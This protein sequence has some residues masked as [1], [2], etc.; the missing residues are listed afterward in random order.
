MAGTN[1]TFGCGSFLPGYGPFNFPDFDVNGGNTKG[2][3]GG[4]NSQPPGGPIVTEPPEGSVCECRMLGTYTV[5]PTGQTSF[6][7]IF[8]RLEAQQRCREIVNGIPVDDSATILQNIRL[9]ITQQGGSIV[10]EQGT[11][12]GPCAGGAP[13]PQAPC[14]GG[15]CPPIVIIY[16]IPTEQGEG[17]DPYDVGE[18]PPPP[19]LAEPPGP[20][21]PPPPSPGVPGGGGILGGVGGGGGGGGGGGPNS[22]VP[23]APNAPG[24]TGVGDGGGVIGEPVDDLPEA[25]NPSAPDPGGPGGGGGSGPNSGLPTS[26]E[27]PGPT[28]VEGGVGGEGGTPIEGGAEIGLPAPPENRTRRDYLAPETRP[29]EQAVNNLFSTKKINLSDPLV[30]RTLLATSP[31]GLQDPEVFISQ[32]NNTSKFV[33]NTSDKGKDLFADQIDSTLLYLLNTSINSLDWDSSKATSFSTDSI[34][35]SLKPEVR[36]IVLGIK[37]YNGSPISNDQIFSLIG[38]RVLDGTIDQITFSLLRDL[39]NTTNEREN[40]EISRSNNPVVNEIA[41]L[42]LMESTFFPLNFSGAGGLARNTLKNYKSLASDV[43]RYVD[44]E[45]GGVTQRHYV[46]DDDTFVTR[47]TLSL[48]D[49]EFFEV[50]LAGETTRFYAKSEDDHAFIV[51]Q[52]IR[53]TVINL[54]GGTPD[55][56]ISVSGLAIDQIEETYSL[57]GA[58]KNLYFLSCVLDTVKS[59]PEIGR[60]RLLN[61]TEAEFKYV[62]IENEED[63]ASINEFI[64]NKANFE[65]YVLNEE[66]LIF[67]YIEGGSNLK[68]SQDDVIYEAPKENKTNPILLRQV[69]RYLILYPTNRADFLIFNDKSTI[70]EYETSATNFDEEVTSS[71]LVTRQLRIGT[72]ICPKFNIPFSTLFVKTTSAGR[73]GQDVFGSED[74]QA[75]VQVLDVDSKIYSEGFKPDPKKVDV[76]ATNDAVRARQ[77]TPLRLSTEILQEIDNNYLLGKNGIG[78]S[79]TEFDLFSRFNIV[80]YNK[81]IRSSDYEEIKKSLFAGSVRGVK[82]VPAVRAAD[83][84]IGLSKTQLITRRADAPADT[85]LPIKATA[86]GRILS[87]PTD[88]ELPQETPAPAVSPRPVT[89]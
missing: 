1:P 23:N 28:G 72:S 47:S 78:K 31:T 24:P 67:D 18:D 8:Y 19:P 30:E 56:L 65:T 66:D 33:R 68:L 71:G 64:K 7:F 46:N 16:K 12:G 3:N 79:I 43:D 17:G 55:K 40:Y 81:F 58:R 6:G 41:A 34:L 84:R 4:S 60:S 26:P 38:S 52:N 53:E 48:Q 62:P 50:T 54:L 70:I 32:G 73:E 51:P 22:G 13:T 57:S 39:Y 9:W 77:K 5:S 63:L 86:S 15:A 20:T 44:I 87:P 85:F 69:P 80:E 61:R 25:G 74:T 49:G 2:P 45:I 10:S 21:S 27:A 11:A 83:A 88:E 37:T 82:V 42:R 59:E 76:I 89:P 14:E 29:S 36:R 35:R 75:R